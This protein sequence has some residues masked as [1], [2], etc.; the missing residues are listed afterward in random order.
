MTDYELKYP[1]GNFGV[2]QEHHKAPITACIQDIHQFPGLLRE[3]VS[4]LSDEQLDTPYRPGGWT[5]RQLVHHVAD[6]HMNAYMRFKW[7][8]TE[9]EPTIKPYFQDRW[10]DLPDTREAPISI[11][12]HFLEGLHMRWGYLLDRLTEETLARKFSHPEF[13]Y[14]LTVADIIRM[15]SWHGRHHLAHIARLKEREAW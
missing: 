10:A 4:P 13:N 11:S 8:L 2:D 1:I 5:V 9:Y 15:Y 6:S 3:A 7:T 14:Q 12:L